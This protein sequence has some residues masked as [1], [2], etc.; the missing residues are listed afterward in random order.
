[1]G[2]YRLYS[3]SIVRVLSA[4]ESPTCARGLEGAGAGHRLITGLPECDATKYLDATVTLL[5]TTANRIV[6]VVVTILDLEC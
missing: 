5:T 3:K 4:I 2:K 6:L 1:M